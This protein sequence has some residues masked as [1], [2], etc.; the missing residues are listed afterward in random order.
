MAEQASGPPLSSQHDGKCV[1]LVGLGGECGG[2]ELRSGGLCILLNISLLASSG[3][4]VT[5]V[6]VRLNVSAAQ[7]VHSSTVRQLINIVSL[8]R[9]D[10]LYHLINITVLSLLAN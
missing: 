8:N 4:R 10:V 5:A 1:V 3:R 6:S 7:R 2:L 9:S